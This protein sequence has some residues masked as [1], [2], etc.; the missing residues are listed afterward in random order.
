MKNLIQHD[1]GTYFT[2]EEMWEKVFKHL[3]QVVGVAA[4]AVYHG[5]INSRRLAMSF[6]EDVFFYDTEILI[7]D[8]EI[9][10]RWASLHASPNSSIIQRMQAAGNIS[11]AT[12]CDPKQQAYV[13]NIKEF[14]PNNWLDENKFQAIYNLYLECAVYGKD[15]PKDFTHIQYFNSILVNGLISYTT[16]AVACARYV[17]KDSVENLC[18]DDIL[19]LEPYVT[20]KPLVVFE[21]PEDKWFTEEEL[22][23]KK[24]EQD[25]KAREAYAAAQKQEAERIAKEEKIKADQVAKNM[26]VEEFKNTKIKICSDI[27]FFKQTLD[28]AEFTL[29]TAVENV[30]NDYSSD[31]KKDPTLQ[32]FKEWH[33]AVAMFG[34]ISDMEN[35]DDFRNGVNSI[36]DIMTANECDFTI[37]TEELKNLYRINDTELEDKLQT[38]N[39]MLALVSKDRDRA[40]SVVLAGDLVRVLY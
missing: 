27:E 16:I 18:K 34:R 31:W 22:R 7:E 12:C 32:S 2:Y 20:A 8:L 9:C 36:S 35:T 17:C 24:A 11:L 23:E 4:T 28:P 5:K 26:A 15:V 25:R 30:F 39:T 38:I 6:C 13:R 33:G 19:A 3:L 14:N 10:R 37:P 29:L 1:D 21:S 40:I